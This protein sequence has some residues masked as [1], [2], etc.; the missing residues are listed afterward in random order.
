MSPEPPDSPCSPRRSSRSPFRLMTK[1][2]MMRTPTKGTKTDM[3]ADFPS[4]LRSLRP[5]P[6]D[7]ADG[8][9]SDLLRHGVG[10]ERFEVTLSALRWSVGLSWRV[11]TESL[12][13]PGQTATS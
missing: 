12:K 8:R 3:P 1:C 5:G 2:Q 13:E 11:G 6:S 7:L 4:G 10:P 9:P